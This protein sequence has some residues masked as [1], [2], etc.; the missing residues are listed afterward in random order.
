MKRK[1]TYSSLLICSVVM[2]MSILLLYSGTLGQDNVTIEN[3][4]LVKASKDSVTIR[5]VPPSGKKGTLE[6]EL[7]NLDGNMLAKV[8]QKHQGKPLEVTFLAEV[9]AEDLANYYLRFR[10]DSS[11]NYR[12]QSLF[13]LGEILE[14]TI[15]GQ[16]EFVAGTRPV[17]R[18]LVRDRASGNVIEGAQ[19]AVE[20][21]M[22]KR[23]FQSLP[24]AAMKTV[25]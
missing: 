11:E 16:R 8:M 13:Y 19:V 18:I 25:K 5:F 17:I 15:L 9:N 14:T 22:K 23:F 24:L 3:S 21:S 1:L 12:K 7:Y 10:F 4:S 6:A 20:L 2:L